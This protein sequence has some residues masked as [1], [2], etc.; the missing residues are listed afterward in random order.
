VFEIEGG[1]ENAFQEQYS[2]TGAICEYADARMCCAHW[3]ISVC[4]CVN[5]CACVS[6]SAW[7]C[8]GGSVFLL[9]SC[10]SHPYVS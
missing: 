10:H 9:L 6:W 5:V 7:R 4:V 8:V 1:G 3:C 2:M